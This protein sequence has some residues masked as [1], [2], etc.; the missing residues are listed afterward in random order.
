MASAKS[1]RLLRILPCDKS[2]AKETDNQVSEEKWTAT[3]L[4]NPHCLFNI[5]FDQ[6]L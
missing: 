1:M 3:L 4:R 5:K 6:R 2:L